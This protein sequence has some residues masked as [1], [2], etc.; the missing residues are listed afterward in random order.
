MLHVKLKTIPFCNTA[1]NTYNNNDNNNNNY[2]GHQHKKRV[3][4]YFQ[5]RTCPFASFY[6]NEMKALSGNVK[7]KRTELTCELHCPRN[8]HFVTRLL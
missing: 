5:T 8:T 1:N 7:G 6:V 3:F 4:S 2:G